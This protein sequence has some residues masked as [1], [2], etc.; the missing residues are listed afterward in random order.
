MAALKQGRLA[1]PKA[2]VKGWTIGNRNVFV[3]RCHV[4]VPDRPPFREPGF[5]RLPV[6]HPRKSASIRVP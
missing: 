1:A 4:L 3:E 2:R 6:A 5:A